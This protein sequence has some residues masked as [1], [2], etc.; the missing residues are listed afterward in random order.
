MNIK[1]NITII[2]SKI[3]TVLSSH[4]LKNRDDIRKIL[5]NNCIDNI[6]SAVI[7]NSVTDII[8]R[9]NNASIGT[10]QVQCQNSLEIIEMITHNIKKKTSSNG[11]AISKLRKFYQSKVSTN[12]AYIMVINYDSTFQ[13]PIKVKIKLLEDISF[14]DLYLGNIG[15]GG[16]LQISNI[17]MPHTFQGTRSDWMKEFY[18]RSI[19]LF[20]SICNK[21]NNQIIPLCLTEEK[22]WKKSKK[23]VS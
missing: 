9:G 23:N 15:S 6:I 1:N 4:N 5:D 10:Y 17:A 18:K 8:P 19:N 7:P 13:Q 20:L 16:Q 2:Q 3:E 14:T 21:I 12:Y 22:A 11:I